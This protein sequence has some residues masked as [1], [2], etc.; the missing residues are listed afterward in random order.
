M[1]RIIICICALF[2]LSAIQGWGF[3]WWSSRPTVCI[4]PHCGSTAGQLE[5]LED[6]QA[7]Y[8]RWRA[9]AK[10]EFVTFYSRYDAWSNEHIA[11]RGILV[12]RNHARAT[13]L[14]MHGYTSNKIDMGL[15]RL[16]FSP[17][18]LFLFDFRAHGE[19]V[20]G[21]TSTFGYDEVYDV[22]AAVDFLREN[23]I[24]KNLPI[25]GYGFSMGAATAI[26]AQARDPQLFTALILDCP[27]DST[28]ALV[29]RGLD[30][31]LGKIYIP[32]FGYYEIPGRKFLEKHAMDPWIQPILLF[33]LRIFAGMDASRITTFPKRVCPC[34]SAK[35]IVIPA[36]FITCYADDRVPIDAVVNVYQNIQG[37]KRLWVTRGA[38]HFGSLFNNPELYQQ[39][40]A[41]FIEKVLYEITK[42][43]RQDRVLTDVSIDEL[44][45]MHERL[46]TYQLPQETINVLYPQKS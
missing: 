32:W 34:D 5:V 44:K 40:I 27:F 7:V 38:R 11:R 6:E 12:T 26:Q 20:E 39:M 17:Y 41:N 29:K 31:A 45:H 25:I 37:Y 16:L 14:V 33:F 42:K 23:P 13:V 9:Y 35:S 8:D 1:R 46:Y 43:E 15:L 19:D 21:Q 18:N 24:T 3:S 22:V 2:W 30:K 36:Q 28:D 4:G 10:D